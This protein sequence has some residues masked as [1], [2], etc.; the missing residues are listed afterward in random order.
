MQSFLFFWPVKNFEQEQDIRGSNPNLN[1]VEKH[2]SPGSALMSD[3]FGSFAMR[4]RNGSSVWVLLG[5]SIHPFGGETALAYMLM[6]TIAHA[7]T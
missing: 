7:S 6:S 1:V 5:H 4:S 2:S 3:T